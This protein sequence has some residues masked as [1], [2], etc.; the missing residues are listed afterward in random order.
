MVSTVHDHSKS[1]EKTEILRAVRTERYACQSVAKLAVP[2]ERVKICLRQPVGNEV[3]VW[4]H[5]KTDKAFY[6]GLMVCGSV[7]TCPV[8]A[9]KISERRKNELK[10]AID[11]HKASGG[12]LALLTLTFSHKRTD[13]LKTTLERFSKAS[14]KLMTGK[15]YHK[16]RQEM[17]II[18]RVKVTEVTYGENGYHPH[19]HIAIFYENEVDL[20]QV[21]LKLYR[22]WSNSCESVGLTTARK[23]GLDLQ[24]A[25]EV[26]AYLSKHGNWS[27]EQELSKAHIKKAK[28]GSMTPFDFLRTYLVT[29]DDKYLK[30]FAEYV[31]CFKGK[32]QVHWSRG[33]KDYFQLEDKSD[34]EIAKEK[35]EQ[36]DILGRL[37]YSDWKQIL[38][39]DQRAQLLTNIEKFGFDVGLKKTLN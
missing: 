39:M 31:E 23:Y 22:L 6:T 8:C 18:G 37:T 27:L 29:E 32:R 1:D 33:L 15:A 5:Q 13:K 24:G 12:R 28:H 19:A 26:A 10:Q 4:R 11:Q 3:E 35:V 25:E 30:L 16:I 14:T 20:L 2:N 21:Q 17:G 36:A 34:E 38:R 7:W 9:A